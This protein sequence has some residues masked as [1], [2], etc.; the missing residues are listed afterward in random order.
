[1]SDLQL[2]ICIISQLSLK[3]K[4]WI[5]TNT[6]RLWESEDAKLWALRVYQTVSCLC[7]IWIMDELVIINPT[8]SGTAVWWSGGRAKGRT[9]HRKQP[10]GAGARQPEPDSRSARSERAVC[11]KEKN[12][13]LKKSVSD[14]GAVGES[15]P[16]CERRFNTHGVSIAFESE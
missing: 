9:E 8:S 12:Q 4:A 5:L 1:M 14:D 15:A 2:I 10:S 13:S 16:M 7:H 11:L 3:K 6:W